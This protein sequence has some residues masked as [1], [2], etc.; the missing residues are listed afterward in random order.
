MLTTF[1]TS[2]VVTPSPLDTDALVVTKLLSLA[3]LPTVVSVLSTLTVT[4]PRRLPVLFP[5]GSVPS[6][7]FKP[8]R[9][10]R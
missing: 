3:L 2:W 1:L 4:L 7:G 5:E 9:G 6:K 8:R 10:P